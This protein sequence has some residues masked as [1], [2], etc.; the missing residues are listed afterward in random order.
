M[1]NRFVLMLLGGLVT[2]GVLTSTDFALAR[3]GFH[4]SG[5]SGPSAA[6]AMVIVPAC[7]YA[8]QV[9][10][11]DLSTTTA[12][13]DPHWALTATPQG[14]GGGGGGGGSGTGNTN[15]MMQMNQAMTAFGGPSHATLTAWTALPGNWIEPYA[16]PM[17]GGGPYDAPAGDYTY[18][19]KFTLACAPESYARL[20]ISG[21]IAA[22]NRFTAT[23]N[24]NNLLASCSGSGYCFQ[25]P[26]T[27]ISSPPLSAYV[28]GT[29][30]ITIVV[31]N[32]GGP[33]GL[34]VQATLK[35]MCGKMCCQMLPTRGTRR[36]N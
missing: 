34:A 28:Q 4:Q 25:S 18:Q 13:T 16:A 33:T 3:S 35:A 2:S 19:L 21:V 7:Q 17:S 27:T 6:N 23:L 29:N 14:G 11:A 5:S 31:H 24:N 10:T 9:V 26:G 20:N 30:T 22:D 15:R 36:A 8:G 1:N 32:D 12:G